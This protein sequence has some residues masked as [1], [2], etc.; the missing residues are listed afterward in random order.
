MLSS[1]FLQ[2]GDA[3]D[4]KVDIDNQYR[5]LSETVFK[6]T[7]QM[8]KI[9]FVLFG[10]MM[11]WTACEKDDLE[12]KEEEAIENYIKDKLIDVEPTSSGLYFI[13]KQRQFP[14]VTDTAT[15]SHGDVIV[16]DMVGKMLTKKSGQ[17]YAIFFN[18]L[19]KTGENIRFKYG[20][21]KTFEG[22]AEGLKYV[23]EGTVVDLIVPSALAYGTIQTGDVPKYTPLLL[24]LTIHE[25]IRPGEDEVSSGEK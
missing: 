6:N 24:Q 8:K 7:K 17:D 19:D 5:K 20:V 10:A 14:T 13:V 22:L 2:L 16:F 25:I 21:D 18:N 3:R 15:P 4:L 12:L 1:D 9:L 23:Q 11:L